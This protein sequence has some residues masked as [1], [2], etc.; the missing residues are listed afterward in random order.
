[1]RDDGI[2]HGDCHG[3][4]VRPDDRGVRSLPA[5]PPV[6]SALLKPPTAWCDPH[7]RPASHTSPGGGLASNIG[8]Q[9]R[10]APN[11]AIGQAEVHGEIS[12][13]GD[14]YVS[15]TPVDRSLGA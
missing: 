2:V 1:M 9:V 5:R 10:S 3:L 6:T 4:G 15:V 14:S 11:P 8:G 7:I 13:K 12:E